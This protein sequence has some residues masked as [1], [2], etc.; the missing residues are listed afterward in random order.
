MPRSATAVLA[1]ALS[2]ALLT[3]CN[4]RTEVDYYP[5]FPTHAASGATVTA[6]P[7]DAQHVNWAGKK[8]VTVSSG[9]DDPASVKAVEKAIATRAHGAE[10]TSLRAVQ[11][12]EQEAVLDQAI[13]IKP[14]LIIGIG[15]NILGA[16]DLT[17]AQF[18]EQ[19]FVV[20]GGQLAEPTDNVQAI[21]WPGA[22]GRAALASDKLPFENV[23]NFAS[24]AAKLALSQQFKVGNVGLVHRLPG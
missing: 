4:S 23:E 13:G 22:D 21:V 9:L 17:S 8:V 6:K 7:G 24:P 18:L 11:S 5:P 15:P 14:D 10:I 19:K 2:G 20:I 12:N 16:I 1:L 3:G